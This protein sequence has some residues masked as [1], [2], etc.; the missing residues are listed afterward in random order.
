MRLF[1]A[2]NFTPEFKKELLDAAAGLR[3]FCLDGNF[4][5]PENLHLTLAFIGETR[6]ISGAAS[7]V[8]ACS[9]RPFDLAVGSFGQFRDL[10][11]AGIDENPALKALA[12]S[13]QAELRKRGFAIESRPFKPHITLARRVSLSSPLCAK[14][15][16]AS[17]TVRRVSLMES[18]RIN[19]ILT[20]SEI[21]GKDLV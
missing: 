6:N 7:A 18:D 19:G 12:E 1:V 20:Y 15:P 8:A 21:S 3:K 17:M 16:K 2:V 11:W 5:R 13:I 10:L 4:T 14:M 9:A